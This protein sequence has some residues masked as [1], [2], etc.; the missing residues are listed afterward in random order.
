LIL[1]IIIILIQFLFHFVIS[2][3]AGA[4]R[5][6][7]SSN[8]MRASFTIFPIPAPLYYSLRALYVFFPIVF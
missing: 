8:F 5:E 3:E 7:A 1:E 2:E 4:M 6:G